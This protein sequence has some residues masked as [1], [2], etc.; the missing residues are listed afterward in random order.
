MV[1]MYIY[2]GIGSAIIGIISSIF[3]CF[4]DEPTP[5]EILFYNSSEENIRKNKIISLQRFC[6]SLLT[7][8][9]IV[10]LVLVLYLLYS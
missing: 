6:L 4:I 3:E 8:V 1:I 5:V 10:L 9:A 2:I 7:N